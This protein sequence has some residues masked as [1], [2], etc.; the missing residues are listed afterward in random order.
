[1]DVAWSL[2]AAELDGAPISLEQATANVSAWAADEY[3]AE[4]GYQRQ[5]L[6]INWNRYGE[7]ALVAVRW[8][9]DEPDNGEPLIPREDW[10]EFAKY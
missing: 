3:P 5:N 6:F 7:T 4:R 9:I 2:H 1:M 10:P 8:L